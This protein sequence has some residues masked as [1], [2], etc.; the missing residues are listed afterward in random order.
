M[1]IDAQ[2]AEMARPF[3]ESAG[4]TFPTVV[5]R[6]NLLSRNYG[7]KAIPN[8]LF[9]DE[10]GNIR[11]LKYSGFDIIKSEFKR[12]AEAWVAT[13]QTPTSAS[14][15]KA[16]GTDS[17]SS[18]SEA[19]LS[20]RQRHEPIRPWAGR[21]SPQPLAAGRRSGAGQLRHPQ[22]DMGR[23]APRQVLRRRRGLR[24]AEGT[25]VQGPLTNPSGRG[26]SRTA[27]SPFPTRSIPCGRP[28][29]TPSLC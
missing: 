8:A 23:R 20:L 4:A 22:A 26:G 14:P 15:Q 28:C 7:F 9:I 25:A 27:R 17:E 10:G 24:L 3:V 12:A 29:L 5:D 11:Y 1:A 19:V 18:H 16:N 2:G 13:G 21:G 6:N